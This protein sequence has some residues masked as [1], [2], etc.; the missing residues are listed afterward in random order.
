[1]N[2]NDQRIKYLEDT[3]N[4]LQVKLNFLMQ[5][6]IT[7]N[8]MLAAT[9]EKQLSSVNINNINNTRPFKH[10][11]PKHF[12][13]QQHQ[14]RYFRNNNTDNTYVNIQTPNATESLTTNDVTATTSA[15]TVVPAVAAPTT[16][17][18]TESSTEASTTVTAPAPKKAPRKKKT[19][20]TLADVTSTF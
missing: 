2:N 10:Y 13:V 1:M 6:I 3:V 19:E 8:Q 4:T 18:P 7:S 17:V 20:V 9:L 12:N 15:V 16:V 11:T 5:N 14:P